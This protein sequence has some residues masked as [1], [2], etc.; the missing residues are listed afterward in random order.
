MNSTHGNL[1]WASFQ[2][3]GSS[4]GFSTTVLEAAT[5][6]RGSTAASS[7]LLLQEPDLELME[8]LGRLE[9]QPFLIAKVV[10]QMLGDEQYAEFKINHGSRL[11]TDD[12]GKPLKDEADQEIR[13]STPI[14]AARLSAF[15][16]EV[17]K[18]TNAVGN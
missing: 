15:M 9:T 5:V 8:L 4:A 13:E 10:Q 6:G 12:D 1:C 18:V 2:A 3:V 11:K 16:D 7:A 14:T 17:G